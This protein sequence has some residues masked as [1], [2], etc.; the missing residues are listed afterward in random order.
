[1]VLFMYDECGETGAAD[2]VCVGWVK[3]MLN[4]VRRNRVTLIH[5]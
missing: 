5:A 3:E 2:R 4:Q 1:M